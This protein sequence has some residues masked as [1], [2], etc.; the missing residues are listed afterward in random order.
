M[1]ADGFL[2]LCLGE[3]AGIAE[4]DLPSGVAL[5]GDGGGAG[6][7]KKRRQQARHEAPGKT[8]LG[9]ALV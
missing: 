4:L 2:Q 9:D 5:S 6:K 8:R 7:E 3:G 1:D